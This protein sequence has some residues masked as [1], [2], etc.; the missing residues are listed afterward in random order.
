MTVKTISRICKYRGILEQKDLPYRGRGNKYVEI[1]L[2]G[3]IVQRPISK[4]ARNAR[5]LP[6]LIAFAS[7]ENPEHRVRLRFDESGYYIIGYRR[8]PG[9]KTR[10]LMV[11]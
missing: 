5:R 3:F 11:L 6:M 7:H 9:K 4:S 2:N 10:A 1:E 8:V